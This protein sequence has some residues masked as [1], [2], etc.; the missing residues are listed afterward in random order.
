MVPFA[1][2]GASSKYEKAASKPFNSSN[3]SASTVVIVVS[4]N[5]EDYGSGPAVN[6]QQQQAQAQPKHPSEDDGSAASNSTVDD[7]PSCQELS[8][9]RQLLTVTAGTSGTPA[10]W[11]L[12]LGPP[13]DDD[14][15]ASRGHNLGNLNHHEVSSRGDVTGRVDPASVAPPDDEDEAAASW[16]H[17]LGNFNH[18]GT[19]G[20]MELEVRCLRTALDNSLA[21]S[22]LRG[23]WGK[24]VAR[25]AADAA[26]ET[27]LEEESVRTAVLLS[28][29]D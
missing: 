19:P 15:E 26:L 28:K 8:D 2:P 6:H 23:E 14:E 25:A 29:G 27:I 17:N 5:L 10:P 18:H 11:D 24:E 16:S 13:G 7:H 22:G 3:I 4:S 21:T 20:I 1:D 12:P 9:E